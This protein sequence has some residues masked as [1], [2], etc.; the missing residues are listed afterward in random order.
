MGENV[1]GRITAPLRGVWLLRARLAAGQGLARWVEAEQGRFPPW[2]AVFMGAGI[3]LF[4]AQPGEPPAWIGPALAGL[5]LPLVVL[6]WGR[7]GARAATTCLLAAAVGFASASLRTHAMP[8]M[9]GLP[10]GAVAVSGTVVAVEPLP[11]GRRVILGQVTLDGSGVMARGLRLRLRD[12]DLQPVAPGDRLGVRALLRAPFAPAYPGAWDQRRDEYFQGLAG[13]GFALGA[14]HVLVSAHRSGLAEGW[15]RFRERVAA[16]IMAA[17]PG[18]PGAVSA[19]L[20]TGI[21]TAIP[22]AV[23]A[24]FATA[25]LAHI[26]AVAGLHIGIVMSTVFAAARFGLVQ[27]EWAALRWRV[28]QVA[29]VVALAV[30]AFYMAITGMHL[31][32][33]RSFVMA[34]L[35]TLGLLLGRRAISMRS[36]GFAATVLM[37]TQ[38]EAVDGVSFQMSFAAVMVLV[39]GYEVLH[40]LKIASFSHRP[41]WLGWLRR[42]LLL[43]GT[44]SLLAALATAPFVAYHFG[45]VQIYSVLANMLAVPLATFWV[46]PLG[47]AGLLLMPLGLAFLALIPMGWGCALMIAIARIAAGLPAA[48]LSVPPEPL[49]GL[50]IASLGLIW[51]CLWRSRVR[52]LGIGPLVFGVVVMPFFVRVPDILVSPDLRTI[53]VREPE[54]VYLQQTGH[55][56]FTLGEWRRFFAGRPVLVLPAEGKLAGGR[57]A[58]SAEGCVLPGRGDG[59]GAGA[60]AVLIWRAYSPPANCRGVGIII[61]TG[62]LDR[63][64]GAGCA[65]VAVVDRDRVRSGQAIAICLEPDEMRISADRDG[66][67]DWPWLPD[68]PPVGARPPASPARTSPSG[69]RPPASP[70]R[71]GPFPQ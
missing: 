47:L 17:V 70:A 31:P 33:I 45:Q 43:V 60:G 64:P 16:R 53:A 51:L 27:W 5:A 35:V 36:L 4:F 41:G 71:I 25:G 39:A 34:C 20:L 14:A 66:R 57:V 50:C 6:G 13:G 18:P 55:D 62:Y 61:A 12:T 37:L 56:A 65:G 3:V 10:R 2:L 9:P 63:L 11:A 40:S 15:Q 68:R 67:G 32:I 38:P 59:V 7:L 44:T 29:G 69:A 1:L 26:L 19:T 48:T 54:A 42:D 52:L 21:S 58:C 23:R 30:G 49:A 46:L 22:P 28:K 24:D 8:P